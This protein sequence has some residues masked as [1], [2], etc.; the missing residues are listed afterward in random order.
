MNGRINMKIT[1][2]GID[3]Y[4]EPHTVNIRAVVDA[5]VPYCHISRCRERSLLSSAIGSG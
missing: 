3:S 4:G 5:L 2:I 1:R